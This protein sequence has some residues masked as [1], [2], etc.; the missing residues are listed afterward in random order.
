VTSFA[1]QGD[2]CISRA[3]QK[4]LNNRVARPKLFLG[5]MRIPHRG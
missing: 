2:A 5:G 3:S 4:V 1:G